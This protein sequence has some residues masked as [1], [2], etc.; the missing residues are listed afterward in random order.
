MPAPQK[1]K[2]RLLVGAAA[3]KIVKENGTM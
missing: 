3:C 2:N 1:M